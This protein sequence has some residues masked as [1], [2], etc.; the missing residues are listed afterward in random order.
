MMMKKKCLAVGVILL[1]IGVAFAPSINAD[2]VDDEL[3][4]INI[5]FCGLGEKQTVQLTQEDADEVERLFDDIEQ[6]LS[7]VETMDEAGKIFTRQKLIERIGERNG[8][9]LDTNLLCFVFGHLTNTYSFGLGHY[10][11]EKFDIDFADFPF[12][13]FKT[14]LYFWFSL[15]APL[16]YLLT[17]IDVFKIVSAGSTHNN[18]WSN[19]KFVPSSGMIITIGL[20]GVRKRLGDN[21]KGSASDT[22]F[23]IRYG[24]PDGDSTTFYPAFIGF[25]GI[26]IIKDLYPSPEIY[27]IGFALKASI[28]YSFENV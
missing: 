23:H 11:V 18:F 3:I 19:P 8:N 25:N 15:I 27:Y 10:I 5:E 1:F 2:V 12:Q 20:T 14:L 26:K 7:E 24:G 6:R 21:L 13:N 17:P 16:I 22:Y 4:E 28:T 9:I